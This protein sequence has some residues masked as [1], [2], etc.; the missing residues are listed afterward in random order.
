MVDT[1]PDLL[2]KAEAEK[3]GDTLGDVGVN[4][5]ASS[6]GDT[7]ENVKEETHREM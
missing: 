6:L 2:P 1:L 5:L 7:V 3:L 4:G